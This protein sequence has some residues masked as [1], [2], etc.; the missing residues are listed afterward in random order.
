MLLLPGRNVLVV[1][2]RL[3]EKDEPRF[4]AGK[5]EAYHDGVAKVS[6]YSFVRDAMSGQIGRKAEL[7]TKFIS[8][9]SGTLIV[10][11]LPEAVRLEALRFECDE[12]LIDLTDGAGF[13]MHLSE[14][15]HRTT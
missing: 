11:E 12:K 14:W 2:R 1:H 7:R 13:S 4:F 3:Y 9:S 15:T 5:V 8:L 10:Y 6:G